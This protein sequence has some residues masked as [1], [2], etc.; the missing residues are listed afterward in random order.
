MRTAHPALPA[1]PSGP[2]A[3]P[4]I[5]IRADSANLKKEAMLTRTELRLRMEILPLS[6]PCLSGFLRFSPRLAVVYP[7]FQGLST[8]HVHIPWPSYRWELMKH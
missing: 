1:G 4:A 2:E 8:L 5:D 7:V 3:A 6:K